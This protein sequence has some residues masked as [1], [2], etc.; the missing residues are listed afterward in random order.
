MAVAQVT[1]YDEQKRRVW[2]GRADAYAYA[3]TFGL[4][5]A[6]PIEQLLD[7]V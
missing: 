5:C 1:S 2:A 7:A 4:L 6:H 3:Q